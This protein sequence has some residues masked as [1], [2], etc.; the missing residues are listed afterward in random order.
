[1]LNYPSGNRVAKLSSPTVMVDDLTL[2][3]EVLLR[4]GLVISNIY[5]QLMLILDSSPL[6]EPGR[7]LSCYF[8]PTMG[9]L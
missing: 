3:S 8:L 5:D 7:R 6:F 1:M 9:N 4:R 2:N